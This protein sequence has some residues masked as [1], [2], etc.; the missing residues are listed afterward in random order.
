V[1][2]GLLALVTL[3]IAGMGRAAK[4]AR[5]GSKWVARGTV[6]SVAQDRTTLRIRH[7]D[8]PGYMK[9][10]TMTFDCAPKQVE[11]LGPND[12]V[13]FQFEEADDNRRPLLWIRRL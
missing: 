10:M 5:R 3:S 13:E 8:I 11:G 7:E 9:A 1:L 4:S 12:R 2:S 6:V